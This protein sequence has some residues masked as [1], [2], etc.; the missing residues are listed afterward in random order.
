MILRRLFGGGGGDDDPPPAIEY[1][2]D[3]KSG[4]FL[5]MA[6]AAPEGLSAAELSVTGAHALDFGG[7]SKTRRVLELEGGGAGRPDSFGR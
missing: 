2:W 7:P 4:D 6:L 3:L 1:A 5:K